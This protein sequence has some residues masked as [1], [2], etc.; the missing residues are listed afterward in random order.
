MFTVT[1]IVCTVLWHSPVVV[2]APD[3]R[4]RITCGAKVKTIGL[5]TPWN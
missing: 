1:G 2:R 5:G 3:V 4:L